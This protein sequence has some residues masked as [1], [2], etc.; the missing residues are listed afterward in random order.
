MIVLYYTESQS[1]GA[2]DTI[3]LFL[4]L[5]KRCE[6]APGGRRAG[7]TGRPRPGAG[8]PTAPLCE[9]VA[10]PLGCYFGPGTPSLDCE[11]RS[12]LE[13]YLFTALPRSAKLAVWNLASPSFFSVFQLPL[14]RSHGF[15]SLIFS[16]LLRSITLPY[17]NSFR[18]PLDSFDNYP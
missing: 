3:A 8:S 13:N 16:D 6:M 15:S 17:R 11:N 10:R 5:G 7:G 9:L 1:D 4:D 18:S 12:I 14:Q 2:Y